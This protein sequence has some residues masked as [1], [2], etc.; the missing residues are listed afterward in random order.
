LGEGSRGKGDASTVEALE[1]VV[2]T[3]TGGEGGKRWS[4]DLKFDR[5]ICDG[6]RGS[7]KKQL[8]KVS[9]S[10]VVLYS[11]SC[12]IED[13]TE[14]EGGGM[15]WDGVGMVVHAPVEGAEVFASGQRAD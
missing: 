1:C 13:T 12:F 8:S 15:G 5:V 10:M 9:L 11:R 4:V 14:L 2:K 3:C 7:S 6:S